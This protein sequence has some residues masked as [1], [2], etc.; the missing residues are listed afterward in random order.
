MV[1]ML[2]LTPW[3]APEFLREVLARVAGDEA[4]RQEVQGNSAL[5]QQAAAVEAQRSAG[6]R[7]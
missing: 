6:A 4:A 5:A 7:N 1:E 3:R 2:D